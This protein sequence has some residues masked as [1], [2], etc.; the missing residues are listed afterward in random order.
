MMDMRQL[1]L[2]AG[3]LVH[4]TM[5]S[6]SA[7]VMTSHDLHYLRTDAQLNMTFPRSRSTLQQINTSRPDASRWTALK[8]SKRC[9]LTRELTPRHGMKTDIMLSSWLPCNGHAATMRLLFNVEHVLW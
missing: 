6:K 3:T 8:P 4:R 9:L 2:S 5:E 1:R 7:H